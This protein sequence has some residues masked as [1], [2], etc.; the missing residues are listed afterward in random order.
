MFENVCTIFL[1]E[2][3]HQTLHQSLQQLQK[4]NSQKRAGQ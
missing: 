3:G 2:T 1:G 4:G